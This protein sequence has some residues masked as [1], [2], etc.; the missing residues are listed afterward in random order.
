MWYSMVFYMEHADF[1]LNWWM[2]C[3]FRYLLSRRKRLVQLVIYFKYSQRS[4]HSST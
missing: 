3:S 2:R 4:E 1:F